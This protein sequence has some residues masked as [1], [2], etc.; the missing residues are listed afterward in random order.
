M[1]KWKNT[2]AL[3]VVHKLL[4][5]YITLHKCC[6]LL[7]TMYT[8]FSGRKF[9]ILYYKFSVESSLDIFFLIVQFLLKKSKV[10]R[11]NPVKRLH[12][13]FLKRTISSEKFYLQIVLIQGS[14]F[15]YKLVNSFTTKQFIEK[16]KIVQ[17]MI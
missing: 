11:L 15:I 1:V 9:Y 4:K 12:F 5:A 10:N 14:V 13:L 17:T 2:F 6:S 3:N 8:N 16:E 7:Y